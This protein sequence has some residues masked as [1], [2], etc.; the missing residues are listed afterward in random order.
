MSRAPESLVV[1][2]IKR[3]VKAEYP[4]SHV[5]KVHG[6]LYQATGFPDLLVLIDGRAYALEIKHVKASETADE[7]RDRASARQRLVITELRKA[8]V[9]AD[10]VTGP[11]EALAVISGHRWFFLPEIA[12]PEPV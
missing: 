6:S 2:S 5:L 3:A 9:P 7:A 12:G 8:G 10:V 11:A 4:N 1:D